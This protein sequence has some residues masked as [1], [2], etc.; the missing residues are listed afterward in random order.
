MLWRG[1]PHSWKRARWPLAVGVKQ[2]ELSPHLDKRREE[3]L[4]TSLGNTDR[5]WAGEPVRFPPD[6]S[7][8]EEVSTFEF[9]T[10]LEVPE[11]GHNLP[12]QLR[13]LKSRLWRGRLISERHGHDLAAWSPAHRLRNLQRPQQSVVP[14]L[15]AR[16]AKVYE[17]RITFIEK[18]RRRG[19]DETLEALRTALEKAGVEFTNGKR[20]G[21]K[22]AT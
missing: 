1:F 13:K 22:L 10:R 6:T 20:P 7:N 5:D 19:R 18:G 2:V 8:E 14:S 15:G 17:N 3:G 4:P 21:V 16:K 9:T 11:R 12:F